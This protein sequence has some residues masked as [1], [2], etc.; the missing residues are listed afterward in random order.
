M[1][2]RFHEF[3]NSDECLDIRDIRSLAV[4]ALFKLREEAIQ[5]FFRLNVGLGQKELQIFRVDVQV[6]LVCDAC[7]VVTEA[8]HVALWVHKLD[9]VSISD[10][11]FAG[12]GA[13]EQRFLEMLVSRGFFDTLLK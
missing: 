12:L 2:A 8:A 9:L 7:R 1:D 3:L 13:G 5:T 11:N 6:D 10:N 4:E